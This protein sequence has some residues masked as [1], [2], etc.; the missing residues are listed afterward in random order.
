MTRRTH[1]NH[2]LTQASAAGDTHRVF[3]TPSQ[4]VDAIA[5]DFQAYGPQPDLFRTLAPLLLED[6][7]RISLTDYEPDTVWIRQGEIWYPVT[8][9]NLGFYLIHLLEISPPH[10]NTLADICR[11]VFQTKTAAGNDST[12]TFSGIWVHSQMNGFVCR[13]C[14]KCCRTLDYETGCDDLDI[15]RWQ[16]MDRTDILAWV[17]CKNGAADISAGTYRIWVDPNTGETARPCPWLIPCPD[18]DRFVCAIH[19]IKPE[20]CREYPYTRKHAVM[21]G[22]GGNFTAQ[23]IEPAQ[24][25]NTPS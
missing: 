17:Q 22:C 1:L 10:L 5:M 11:L 9:E 14:G 6:R 25:F 3:L 12:G 7:C 8:D 19:D 16:E 21:T 4:A 20:V 2:L 23:P 24:T 18:H 13:Q 15:R